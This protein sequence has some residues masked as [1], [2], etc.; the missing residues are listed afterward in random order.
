MSKQ[1]NHIPKSGSFLNKVFS[2]EQSK[3]DY[4][5]LEW[6]AKEGLDQLGKE[7]SVEALSRIRNKIESQKRKQSK[8]PTVIPL[9]R[10]G[11]AAA[12]AGILIFIGNHI[13]NSTTNEGPISYDAQET[14]AQDI[15][16]N[17]SS[18]PSTEAIQETI[19]NEPIP[20]E[21]SS[22]K[23]GATNSPNPVIEVKDNTILPIPPP[24]PAE[25]LM[26]IEVQEEKFITEN[27]GIEEDDFEEIASEEIVTLDLPN[28][29]EDNSSNQGSAVIEQEENPPVAFISDE[30]SPND[31]MAD[32]VLPEMPYRMSEKNSL[33]MEGVADSDVE[34]SLYD[35][36]SAFAKKQFQE[37][38]RRFEESNWAEQH[39]N[40]DAMFF[41]ARAYHALGNL[42]QATAIMQEVVDLKAKKAKEARRYLEQ[43]KK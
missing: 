28:E 17:E 29:V 25:P 32:E 6:E 9:W 2:R 22:M 37:I 4:T 5:D 12:C 20:Y 10:Y 3:E 36:R 14:Q 26:R 34:E 7:E 19:T 15:P 23:D 41:A 18:A 35:W 11:A 30:M 38:T 42:N 13:I 21:A 24:P 1:K 8:K 43:W 39:T 31:V 33:S 27:S 40:E 16:Q